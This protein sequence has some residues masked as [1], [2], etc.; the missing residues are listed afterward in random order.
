MNDL[1]L[2]SRE[3][4][5]YQNNK[6]LKT[7]DFFITFVTLHNERGLIWRR[8][9]VGLYCVVKEIDNILCLITKL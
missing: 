2:R 1:G 8:V 3:N 7:N 4:I 9:A 5:R 6:N